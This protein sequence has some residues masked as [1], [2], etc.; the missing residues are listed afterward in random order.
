MRLNPMAV[1]KERESEAGAEAGVDLLPIPTGPFDPLYKV[2]SAVGAWPL[3]VGLMSTSFGL[4]FALSLVMPFET[5][6][7]QVPQPF[8]GLV[9]RLALGR[10]S[11][12]YHADFDPRRVS[13]FAMNHTS[14]LDAHVACW[15]VPHAFC[16]VQHAHHFDIPIYGWLMKR[17]NGIGVTKGAAGQADTVAAQVHDRARRGI[18]ILGFPEGRRTQNGRLLPFR[19]G[20]FAMAR[21]GGIPVVP[22]CVRGLWGILR[23]GEWVLRPGPLDVFVGPQV[24]TQG[25]TDPQIDLMAARFQGFMSDYVERGVVGDALRLDPRHG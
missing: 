6:Q 15:A 10:R 8:M 25:L 18:S 13:L 16:G 22:L 4:G 11:L 7:K 1:L 5:L 17:G 14:L 19:T 24:E 21:R 9:P 12:T 23:R 2:W 3:G 20:L